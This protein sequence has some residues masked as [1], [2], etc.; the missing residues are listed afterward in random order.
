MSRVRW[1]IVGSGFMASL[2]IKDFALCDNTDLV[3]MVSR[4]P[5]TARRNLAEWDIDVPVLSSLDDAIADPNIDLIYLATPHSEHFAAAKQAI[6]GGKHVL[7]EKAFTLN[8]KEAKKLQK[9]AKAK[10]VFLMEAMWSKFNPLLN[11]V[12]RR[13]DSKELGELKYIE[14]RFGFNMPFDESHRLFSAKLGG[15]TSLDQGVYS[16][17]IG[18]WFAGSTP[19]SI[20]AAGTNYKNGTD[21]FASTQITYANGVILNATSAL[22]AF[23]GMDARV[24]FELGY[25]DIHESFWTPTSA[26]VV[27]PITS[28]DPVSGVEITVP[29]DGAGYSHM[30]RKVSQAVLDGKI[31]CEEHTVDYTVKIMGILDK[32]RKQIR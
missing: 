27:G 17:A 19:V 16:V 23:I 20:K 21:A 7:V 25:I 31:E 18:D 2:I 30:I 13:I 28:R 1:A 9:L 5:D 10:N 24:G 4:N 11:E 6:E 14:T 29:K 32:I 15:G 26:T 8:A 3:A 12:K 22:N